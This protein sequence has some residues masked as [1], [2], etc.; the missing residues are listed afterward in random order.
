MSEELKV[1]C[2]IRDA[3]HMLTGLPENNVE[4]VNTCAVAQETAMQATPDPY[5]DPANFLL[6]VMKAFAVRPGNA[7]SSFTNDRLAA[8]LGYESTTAHISALKELVGKGDVVKEDR[9]RYNPLTGR[10]VDSYKVAEHGR[11]NTA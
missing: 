7:R 2:E 9:K 5:T 11:D 10:P 3:I 1:L 8:V 4:F 6:L